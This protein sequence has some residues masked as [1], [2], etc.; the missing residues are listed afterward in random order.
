MTTTIIETLLTMRRLVL[1]IAGTLPQITIS[2]R[3]SEK[4]ADFLISFPFW[5]LAFLVLMFTS[6]NSH[7][8]QLSC[9]TE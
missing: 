5:P 8:S 3:I 4:S 2:S 6:M 7:G 1:A 9:N